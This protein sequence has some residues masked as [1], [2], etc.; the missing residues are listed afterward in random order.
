MQVVG[1]A[2]AF[3]SGAQAVKTRGDYLGIVSK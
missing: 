3:I 2:L 1:Y